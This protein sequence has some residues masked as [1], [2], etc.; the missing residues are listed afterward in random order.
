MTFTDANEGLGKTLPAGSAEKV[1]ATAP[2]WIFLACLS[3][4]VMIFWQLGMLPLLNPDEGRNASVAWDMQRTGAWLVPSYNGLAY[5]D[6]PAFFFKAVAFSLSLFGQSEW[7]ARLPSALFGTGTLLMVFAFCRRE[8]DLRT[9]ALAV[10]VIATTPLFFAFARYVIFDMTLAFFVCGAIFAGYYAE[11]AG[12][13]K[14]KR[15]WSRLSAAAMGFGMLVKGPVG[16]ILPLLVLGVFHRV[17]G[18]RGAMKRLLCWQNILIFLALFVP[19]FVGVSLQRHDFPYYGVVFESLQRFATTKAHRTQP[20]WFYPPVILGTMLFWSLTLPQA[21]WVSWKQ[22]AQLSRAEKLLVVWAIAVTVFFSISQSKLPGY[23][24][25]AVIALG[26]LVAHRF[27]AAFEGCDEWIARS[28]GY[29]LALVS[30]VAAGALAYYY[31]HPAQIDAEIRRQLSDAEEMLVALRPAVLPGILGLAGV[32]AGALYGAARKNARAVFISFVA[33]TLVVFILGL[34][35][36]VA[37]EQHRGSHDIAQ[38]VNEVAPDAEVACYGCFPPGMPFYLG[39]TVTVFT[40]G[41][42]KEI[43]SNYIPFMLAQ[44]KD[45]PGHMRPIGQFKD[46]LAGQ[47]RPVFIIAEKGYRPMLET[48]AAARHSQVRSLDNYK[49]WGL[50]VKPEERQ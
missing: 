35:S 3:A 9:A 17:D 32:T 49:Y 43:Q 36:L 50:L 23:V 42:G 45:W 27:A 10:A 21:L 29:L 40:N 37:A 41:N 33:C 38:H 34:P 15:R 31:T 6:K 46:W 2:G 14:T 18:R 19:W 16:I 4:T 8:F 44:T 11:S 28:G 25:T 30:A 12:E 22:R 24:L 20:F 39:R 26:V 5:L 1:S 13:E 47:K 7:A 48:L